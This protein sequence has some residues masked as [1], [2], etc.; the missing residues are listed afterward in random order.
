MV[1][2]DGGATV[3]MA[4]PFIWRKCLPLNLKLFSVNM[5]FIRVVITSVEGC[6]DTL[7]SRHSFR[8]DIPSLCFMFE[9]RDR[10]SIITRIALCGILL[11]CFSLFMR[12]VVSRI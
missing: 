5:W 6:F 2:Y 3:P 10:T 4:Q 1:A 11:M 12:S 7:F 9:Y 8:A